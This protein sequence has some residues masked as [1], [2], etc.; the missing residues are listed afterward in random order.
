MKAKDLIAAVL[1]AAAPDVSRLV[2]TWLPNGKRHERHWVACNPVRGEK[3][4]S[5]S[6]NIDTGAFYD[7]ADDSVKGGDVIA[8]CAYLYDLKQ[9]DAARQVAADIG[10]HIDDQPPPPARA[11]KAKDPA[12]DDG[13]GETKGKKKSPWVPIMPVPDEAGMPPLAHPVRGRFE[14][15]W[16]Y[17]DQMGHFLGVVYRFRKSDGEKEICPCVYARNEETGKREWRWMH[18]PQP[19]PLYGLDRLRPG[20]PVLLVEGEKCADAGDEML[21]E[22][23]DVVSWPGGGNADGKVDWTPLAGREVIEWPDCDSKHENLTKAERDAGVPKESKPLKAAADQPGIKTMERIAGTLKAIDCQV[24][25]LDVPAPGIQP[26]GWDIADWIEQGAT[27][28]ELVDF[29]SNNQRMPSIE[30]PPPIEAAGTKK[31]SPPKKPPAPPG[32][33]GDQGEPPDHDWMINLLRAKNGDLQPVMSNAKLILEH[34]PQLKGIVFY[35]LFSSRIIKRRRPPWSSEDGDWS[36]VDQILLLEFMQRK[37]NLMVRSTDTVNMAVLGVAWERRTH[38]LQDYLNS[39]PAWDGIE[40]LPDWLTDAF[41]CDKTE[42]T[43]AVGR[44]CLIAAVARAFDP[45]CQVDEMLILDSPQGDHKTTAIMTLF[46]ADFYKATA[47]RPD[48]KD[49]LMGLAGHWVIEIAEMH[50]FTNAEVTLVK[51][52]ISSRV[53]HYRTPY[54]KAEEKHR[55]GCIMWGTSNDPIYLTD[56]TGSRRSLP[57]TVK[58]V[59]LD[60]ITH[61]REMLWAEALARFRAGESWWDYPKDLAKEEQEQ[62]FTEDIWTEKIVRYLEGRAILEDY[63]REGDR[64]RIDEIGLFEIGRHAVGLDV[65]RLDKPTSTRLGRIM[66]R[67]GWIRTRCAPNKELGGYRPYIYKRPYNVK[68]QPEGYKDK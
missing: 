64:R 52:L 38:V 27:V 21:R 14:A 61:A 2:E 26:D 33:G 43:T 68:P 48:N 39:L 65:S 12:G 6:V 55:R 24:R 51:Q 15:R 4:A 10:Y 66:T 49:F 25:L 1:K 63:P 11:I 56:H 57:I 22:L 13:D 5:L 37:Y 45:G 46:G 28:D 20:Y 35:D 31:R 40:R 9:S 17:H 67:L 54:A 42:Y 18:F 47:G 44:C 8:L 34:D 36:E 3:N 23:Y 60:F 29:I 59:D 41:G 58:A 7:H 32:G 19:R 16:L 30:A 62:R 53:D 50:S